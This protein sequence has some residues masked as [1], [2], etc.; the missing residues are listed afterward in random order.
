VLV[1]I[2]AAGN[3]FT[4]ITTLLSKEVQPKLFVTVAVYVF[5]PGTVGVTVVLALFIFPGFQL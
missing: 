4:V 5:A 2:G 3:G 1:A